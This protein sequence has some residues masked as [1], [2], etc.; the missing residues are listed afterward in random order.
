MKKKEENINKLKQELLVM[1]T[2]EIKPNYSELSR[3]YGI[4]RRT[5]K[6]YH[7][8]YEGKSLTR[9]KG[10]ILDKYKDEI[11]EKLELSGATINGTYQYFLKKENIGTYSNFYKY[12][13]KQKLK[14]KRK[15]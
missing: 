13:P 11:K 7:E 6:K 2:L 14:P 3:K 8:G 12:V 9:N 5:V 10:S 4:D 1:D 15:N